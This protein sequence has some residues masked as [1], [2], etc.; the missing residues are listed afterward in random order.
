MDCIDYTFRLS[1]LQEVADMFKLTG[2]LSGIKH[3][4][5][6]EWSD[7]CQQLHGMVICPTGSEPL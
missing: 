3:D 6:R 7:P 2:T 5:G 1:H 4:F